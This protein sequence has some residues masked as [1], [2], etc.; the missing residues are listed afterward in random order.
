[1]YAG[2]DH[3]VGLLQQLQAVLRQDLVAGRGADRR[4][5][6]GADL[7]PVERDVA[8]GRTGAVEDLARGAQVEAHHVGQGEDGDPV[9]GE[10]HGPIV[11]QHG[12]PATR[13]GVPGGVR[14]PG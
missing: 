11:A 5:A 7:D 12:F 14:L 2:D 3:R 1:M 4:A 10:G 9:P 13:R 6:G 8:V